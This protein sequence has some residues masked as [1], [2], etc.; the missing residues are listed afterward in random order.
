MRK[1]RL[2]LMTPAEIAIY[3]AMEEVEKM[4]ADVRLTNAVIKLQEARD[5]VA[6]YIDEQLEKAKE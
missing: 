3:K 1:N 5:E 2:D 6:A 4:E